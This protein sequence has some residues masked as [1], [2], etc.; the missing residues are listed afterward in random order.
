MRF[1]V[2]VQIS[3]ARP[4]IARYLLFCANVIVRKCFAHL[5]VTRLI[6]VSEFCPLAVNESNSAAQNGTATR[7]GDPA[8][9]VCVADTVSLTKQG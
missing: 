5:N 6:F 2:P 9:A 8:G 7:N 1:E 4:N 3:Q